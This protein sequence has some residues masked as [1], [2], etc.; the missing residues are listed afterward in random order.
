MAGG[1]GAARE[2]LSRGPRGSASAAGR[3]LRR[4][5]L[6][7]GHQLQPEVTRQ[8]EVG[9]RKMGGGSWHAPTLNTHLLG[10]KITAQR[11]FPAL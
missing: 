7:H 5:R 11:L 6:L 9:T 10:L 4:T 3:S 8:W 1:V 2:P